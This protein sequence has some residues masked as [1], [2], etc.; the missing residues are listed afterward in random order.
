MF[1]ILSNNYWCTFTNS[2]VG[3]IMGQCSKRSLLLLPSV[4]PGFTMRRSHQQP[5]AMSLTWPSHIASSRDHGMLNST[6]STR[7]INRPFAYLLVFNQLCQQCQVAYEYVT[8]QN[9]P[10]RHYL[11]L[12][13]TTYLLYCK[14]KHIWDA[15]QYFLSSCYGLTDY[16]SSCQ[17]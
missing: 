10:H 1:E 2:H 8:W 13:C 12:A 17:A 9:W 14:S 5:F 16:H 6:Q 7:S 4:K 11:I 3:A 15:G